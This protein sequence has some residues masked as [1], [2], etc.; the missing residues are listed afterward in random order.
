MNNIYLKLV[1]ILGTFTVLFANVGIKTAITNNYTFNYS[2]FG[3][4]WELKKPNENSNSIHKLDLNLEPYL[5]I[6]STNC[7]GTSFTLKSGNGNFFD[8]SENYQFQNIKVLSYITI[9]NFKMYY[10]LQYD[11]NSDEDAFFTDNTTDKV[12]SMSFG[13]SHNKRINKFNITYGYE[14]IELWNRVIYDKKYN[15]TGIINFG[16]FNKVFGTLEYTINKLTISTTIHHSIY[17]KGVSEIRFGSY[18]ED[19]DLYPHREIVELSIEPT[20]TYYVSTL[21]LSLKA[22]L[23]NSDE[24]LDYGISILGKNTQFS[25]SSF[26]LKIERDFKIYN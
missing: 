20:I 25:Y 9:N 24:Y 6:K 12:H 1:L 19:Y 2:Y 16:R 7:Y 18:S 5:C 17:T 22:S 15:I 11:F 21:D 10:S 14:F 8:N 23:G 13:F 26:K 3:E 4:D